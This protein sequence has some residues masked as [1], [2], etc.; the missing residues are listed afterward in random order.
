EADKD[1][2]H[3]RLMRLGHGHRRSVA[4]LWLWSGL[5]SLFVL[6]PVYTGRGNGLVPIAVLAL[7]LVLLTFFHP[8]TRRARAAEAAEEAAREAAETADGEGERAEADAPSS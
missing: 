2:L 7:A 8:G 5:L 3:H 4:I 1:H 6:Y